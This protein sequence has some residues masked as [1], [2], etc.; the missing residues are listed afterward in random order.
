VLLRKLAYLRRLLR[1]LRA[2]EHASQAEVEAQHY[3]V[4]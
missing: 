4:E 2:Y 1:D 3:A